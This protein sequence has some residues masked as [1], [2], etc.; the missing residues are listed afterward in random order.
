MSTWTM[1]EVQ[2]LTIQRAGGNYAAL[3]TWLL[4]APNYGER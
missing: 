4:H 2:E 1:E 3:Q